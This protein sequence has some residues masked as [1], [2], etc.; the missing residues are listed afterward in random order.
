[1]RQSPSIVPEFDDREICVV[2]D[3][4]GA[5]AGRAWR[6]MDEE[7]TDLE[8]VMRD[9]LAGEYSNPVRVVMFNTGEGWARDVSE[10]VAD[11]LVQRCADEGRQLPPSVEEFVSKH[12]TRSEVQ[13]HLPLRGAA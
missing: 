4:F 8:A 2:L 1:M 6:E 13:L 9:L 7:R 10:D 12:R 5:R 3:D 11:E